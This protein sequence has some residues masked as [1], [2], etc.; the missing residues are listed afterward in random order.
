MDFIVKDAKDVP[1]QEDLIIKWSQ[2]TAAYEDSISVLQN[3]YLNGINELINDEIA[4][5]GLDPYALCIEG[6]TPAYDRAGKIQIATSELNNDISEFKSSVEKAYE[7]Q[8]KDEYKKLKEA[9]HR[10]VE[11]HNSKLAEYKSLDVSLKRQWAE[12]ESAK[13]SNQI[14]P[15]YIYQPSL[16]FNYYEKYIA[17]EKKE[18]DALNSEYNRVSQT[19]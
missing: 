16:P 18:I 13:A 1:G 15:R 7:K 11:E 4:T 8:R 3:N 14:I 2:V 5:G 10:A 19:K 12:Y 6:D 9:I 17:E